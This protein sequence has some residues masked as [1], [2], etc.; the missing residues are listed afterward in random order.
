MY[1]I[2]ASQSVG[3]RNLLTLLKIPFQVIPSSL[4]EDKIIGKTPH[5]TIRLR[6]RMK[7]E[8]VLNQVVSCQL[9]VVSEKKHTTYHLQ[10]TTIII[11]A[12]SGAILDNRLIGKPKD[13]KDAARIMK[14]LSGT[15]HELFT[16]VF[17]FKLPQLALSPSDGSPK[18]PRSLIERSLV[19]FRKLSDEDIRIYLKTTNYLRYAGGYALF[20]DQK[21]AQPTL[22]DLLSD[23][24]YADLSRKLCP[25]SFHKDLIAQ[26]DGSVSNVIGLPLEKIIPYFHLPGN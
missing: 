7:G 5:E 20:T 23:I 14:Q 3:R 26:I 16:A 4:D 19:T 22:H 12:D 24:S 10:P 21:C 1:L 25:S 15:T 17:L 18:L 13:Y 6:A 9:S 11:S 2:L 8:E